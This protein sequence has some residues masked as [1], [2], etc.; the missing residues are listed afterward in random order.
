MKVDDDQSSELPITYGVPQESVLGS[1]L[2]NL[3]NNEHETA[4]A[5]ADDAIIYAQQH[6][7]N[8]IHEN[9]MELVFKQSHST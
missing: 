5:Q 8:Q 7:S 4:F 2:F 3:A 9:S 1:I 6:I